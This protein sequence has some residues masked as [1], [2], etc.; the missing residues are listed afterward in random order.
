MSAQLESA[1][2]G[3]ESQAALKQQFD[4][5][6][7]TV[8]AAKTQLQLELSVLKARYFLLLFRCSKDNESDFY[9][10]PTLSYF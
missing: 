9:L 8:T 10:L 4:S 7:S 3:S 1:A 5:Q 2:A 6:L